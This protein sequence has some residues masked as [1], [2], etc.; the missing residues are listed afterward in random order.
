MKLKELAK[1]IEKQKQIQKNDAKG[2]TILSDQIDMEGSQL[3]R[4]DIVSS[5]FNQE[6]LDEM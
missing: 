2:E 1:D 4:D 5:S 3:E 6:K